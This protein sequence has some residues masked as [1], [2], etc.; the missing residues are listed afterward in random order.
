MYPVARDCPTVCWWRFS[1]P[2]FCDYKNGKEVKQRIGDRGAKGSE[3]E[4]QENKK[5]TEW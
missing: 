5:K 2:C 3:E 1:G 4:R